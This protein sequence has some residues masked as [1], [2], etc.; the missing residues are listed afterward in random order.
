MLALATPTVAYLLMVIYIMQET[1]GPVLDKMAKCT[2]A[3]ADS[4]YTGLRHTTSS[5]DLVGDEQSTGD[6]EEA[7]VSG[8]QVR[9]GGPG[10]EYVCSQDYVDFAQRLVSL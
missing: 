6:P 2:S 10:L 1:W 5:S 3:G 9:K 8:P 7:G 4:S